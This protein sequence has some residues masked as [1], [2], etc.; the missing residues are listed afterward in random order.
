MTQIEKMT[1][2]QLQDAV[3]D[4]LEWTPSVDSSHIGVAADHG[5]ITVTGEVASYPEKRAAEK[6]VLRVRGVLAMAGDLRVRSRG[7]VQDSDIAREASEALSRAVDV[8]ADSVQVSVHDHFITLSGHAL[9]AFQRAAA[10]RAVGSL[11][12]VT[13]VYN[14]IRVQPENLPADTQAAITAA[15]LRNAQIEANA[16][17]VR[18]SSGVV[19][20][21]G[22]VHSWS[23]RKQAERAAW[24]APGISNVINNLKIVA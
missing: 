4:E 16:I 23:E 12:G 13:G 22:T 7:P 15:L 6:A 3:I 24:S 18:A 20:L 2:R 11:S 21:E 10:E 9:W 5:A 19:T 14:T 17:E 8:P 1:D